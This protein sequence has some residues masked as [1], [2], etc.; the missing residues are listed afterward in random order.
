M[1]DEVHIKPDLV[2]PRVVEGRTEPQT[3][4][5]D[6]EIRAVWNDQKLGYETDRLTLERHSEDPNVSPVITS[7]WI[8]ALPIQAV[9]REIINR[10]VK[11]TD[12]SSYVLPIL[13][14]MK[15]TNGKVTWEPD[16]NAVVIRD[17]PMDRAKANEVRLREASRIYAIARAF[18]E[19]PIKLV[20]AMFGMTPTGASKLMARAK[21]AGLS[22]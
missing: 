13:T 20:A 19:S 9:F 16:A 7:K 15:V 3:F 17:M 11:L 6:V 22:E 21:E 2:F 10:E 4:Q 12:G 14:E 18:G 1:T 5:W 8:R